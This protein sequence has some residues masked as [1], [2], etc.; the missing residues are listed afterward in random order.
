MAE[1][2]PKTNEKRRTLPQFLPDRSEESIDQFVEMMRAR[3]DGYFAEPLSHE[4]QAIDK[5]TAQVDIEA[6]NASALTAVSSRKKYISPPTQTA[7]AMDAFKYKKRVNEDVVRAGKGWYVVAD[8]LT[9]YELNVCALMG[10]SFALA[11]EWMVRRIELMNPKPNLSTV[12]NSFRAVPERARTILEKATAHHP[13]RLIAYIHNDFSTTVE[14]VY[15]A[16]WLKE[17]VVV[18]IGDSRS[19][20]VR[21][22]SSS[23]EQLTEDHIR[24]A[25][26]RSRVFMASCLSTDKESSPRID[27]FGVAM[28]PGDKIVSLCD[29]AF[30]YQEILRKR[31]GE[32]PT[33]E[34]SLGGNDAE[35]ANDLLPYTR[36]LVSNGRF[37][38]DAVGH[39]DDTSA[40]ALL[41]KE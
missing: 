39:W 24:E 33:V 3:V 17:A 34:H 15:Y 14:A 13:K 38:Q 11:F 7:Q 12:I 1:H 27:V 26:D 30:A 20:A 10:E 18:H 4:H 31:G 36:G 29:G 28:N 40:G 5:E 35:S 21:A 22:G 32:A 37:Y 41:V 9:N 25:A 23:A 16:E 2:T 6:E 8:G 19:Y